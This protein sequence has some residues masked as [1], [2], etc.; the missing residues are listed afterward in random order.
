MTFQPREDGE[1][2]AMHLHRNADALGADR[3]QRARLRQA[4][5]LS[6]GG[7]DSRILGGQ[8]AAEVRDQLKASMDAVVFAAQARGEKVVPYKAEGAQRIKGRD[9]L[10]MLFDS[11]TLTEGQWNTGLVYR[12]LH[13][14][15][16][17]SL[18][19]QLGQVSEGSS[20]RTS[21]DAM[22]R[23]GL[24]AAYAGLRL[25]K[26]EAALACPKRVA[27]LRAVVGEGRTIR[28]LASSG[29]ARKVMAD[30]L[31]EDI[32]KVRASLSETGGLRITGQ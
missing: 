17:S 32:A 4:A 28:S 5:A 25:T 9:G 16:C 12:A 7:R 20:C 6:L 27:V 23:H 18:G 30:R 10:G 29:H 21:T 15:R 22:V 31:V 19:S 24:R 13:E 8:I 14:A 11:G 2:L 26:A 3:D 1:S